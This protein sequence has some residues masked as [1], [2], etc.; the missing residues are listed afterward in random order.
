M[1]F[2]FPD[3]EGAVRRRRSACFA[4]EFEFVSRSPVAALPEDVMRSLRAVLAVSLALVGSAA[5]AQNSGD[6]GGDPVTFAAPPSVYTWSGP[7]GGAFVG[8]NWSDVDRSG[9]ASIGSDGFIGGV[10]TGFN[11][12]SDR[13]VYGL[14]AD[15]GA[16]GADGTGFDIGTGLPLG[17]DAAEFGSVRARVGVDYDPFLF[18]ATGGVAVANNELALGNATDE[19]THFG[20]TLGVGVEAAVTENLSS[21]FEY[22]Y[23]DYESRDYNLGDVKMSSGF[24]EHSIRAG[25]A[26]RF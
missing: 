7:Y 11:L 15:I 17:T 25:L 12:K 22:R 5:L 13:L 14:E 24:D 9:G 3:R 2:G 4:K 8:Y 1:R 26:L 23:S 21:R 10:Y 16:S 19:N 18:F 20:W 6:A